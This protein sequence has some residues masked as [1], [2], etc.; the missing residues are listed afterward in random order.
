MRFGRVFV[1]ALRPRAPD[2]S[3]SI[4]RT[5]GDG[6]EIHARNLGRSR[7]LRPVRSIWDHAR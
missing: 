2:T 3:V 1:A 4:A 5:T 7:E 6:I